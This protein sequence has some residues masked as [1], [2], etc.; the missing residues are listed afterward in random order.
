MGGRLQGKVALII[1]G[2]R[3]VGRLASDE[4]CHVTGAEPGND[5]G[6][7]AL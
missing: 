1:G 3:K 4:P 6:F 5:G 7:I 2:G